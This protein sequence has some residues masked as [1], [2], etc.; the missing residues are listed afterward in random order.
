MLWPDI[1]LDKIDSYSLKNGEHSPN[2]ARISD[3]TFQAKGNVQLLADFFE[4]VFL[5][6]DRLTGMIHQHSDAEPALRT[7]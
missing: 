3:Y 1:G 4:M 2:S 6:I 5:E 7:V